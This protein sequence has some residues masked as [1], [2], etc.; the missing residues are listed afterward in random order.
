MYTKLGDNPLKIYLEDSYV[1]QLTILR[2]LG[3]LL[4]FQKFFK[5][6]SL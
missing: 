1:F 5:I 4:S 3:E 2:N 6:Y